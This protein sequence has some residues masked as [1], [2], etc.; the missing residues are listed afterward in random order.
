MIER[1]ESGISA[2]ALGADYLFWVRDCAVP[3]GL[4]GV[5]SVKNDCSIKILAEGEEEDLM[6]FAEKLKKSTF[7]HPVENFYV[8][9]EEPSGE[10]KDFTVDYKE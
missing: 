7:L 5:V 3:L 9:W 8:K 10:F 6:V 4:E 2:K 1:I